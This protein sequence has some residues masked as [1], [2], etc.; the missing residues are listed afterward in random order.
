[1]K[2]ATRALARR[3][4]GERGATAVEYGLM[5]ALLSLAMF[6]GGYL[7]GVNLDAVFDGFA[8]SLATP[9]PA[10]PP[11]EP[12]PAPSAFYEDCDAV[13]AA[14]KDPIRVGDPGYRPEL[15]P[16]GDGVGCD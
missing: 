14:G 15:D 13:R 8:N 12:P 1:M 9:G 2:A 10:P 6:G 5:V 3:L 11:A 4:L 16:D 7:L